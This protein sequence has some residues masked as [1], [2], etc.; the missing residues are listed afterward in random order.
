MTPIHS[1]DSFASVDQASFI[2]FLFFTLNAILNNMDGI[3]IALTLIMTIIFAVISTP[4]VLMI[5]AGVY[6]FFYKSE[7][8]NALLVS[9]IIALST[10]HLAHFVLFWGG[11]I[12]SGRILV[13]FLV[14]E[15]PFTI[16]Y[17]T[18]TSSIVRNLQTRK[19]DS[20][21]RNEDL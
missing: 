7:A 12:P 1:F 14:L 18:I 5:Q 8:V 20:Q 11:N 15:I 19:L 4:A 10:K 13:T 17:W 21:K 16:A 6:Y 2:P 3:D 9:A